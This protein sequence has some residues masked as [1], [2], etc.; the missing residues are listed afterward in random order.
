MRVSSNRHL[1]RFIYGQF[2]NHSRINDIAY[3]HTRYAFLS[4]CLRTSLDAVFGR[5][6]AAI[7]GDLFLDEFAEG[8][9]PA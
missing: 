6:L 2:E 4:V 8:H 1:L 9:H 3:L 7:G 5:L